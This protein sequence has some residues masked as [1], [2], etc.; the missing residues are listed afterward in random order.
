MN[1]QEAIGLLNYM[2]RDIE[3][4]APNGK[5]AIEAQALTHAIE[6]MKRGQDNFDR[7]FSC[8]KDTIE[9]QVCRFDNNSDFQVRALSY[10]KGLANCIEMSSNVEN[11]GM[12][13][14]CLSLAE[15]EPPQERKD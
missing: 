2:L 13:K 10:S 11:I 12:G 7:H 8:P 15:N 14:E 9:I 5:N 3:N 1:T 6:H 4:D